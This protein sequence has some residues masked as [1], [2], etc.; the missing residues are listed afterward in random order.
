[1]VLYVRRSTAHWTGGAPNRI[2]RLG[3]SSITLRNIET[4]TV[5]MLFMRRV[6]RSAYKT[7]AASQC[8]CLPS[9]DTHIQQKMTQNTYDNY[10]SDRTSYI[11]H[12]TLD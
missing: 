11:P 8:S 10:Y 6:H 9:H 12:L 1:M 3:V 4:E 7:T 2:M 5:S